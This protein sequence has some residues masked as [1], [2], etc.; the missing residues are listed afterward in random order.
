MTV[1]VLPLVKKDGIAEVAKE[2]ELSLREEFTT[3][4]D[5]S[6]AIGRRYRRMDEIGTPYC[7]TV[8]Y[9]SLDDRTVTLR[10]RDSMEQVRIGMDEIVS[11]IKEANKNYKRVEK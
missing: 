8:D 11:A 1:A 10:Y 7:I 3:F 9:Q 4:F 2:L 6:G 5:L